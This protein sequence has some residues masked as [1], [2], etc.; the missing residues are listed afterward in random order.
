LLFILGA[1][2]FTGEL[3]IDFRYVWVNVVQSK[4]CFK[5]IVYTDY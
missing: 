2:S 1:S 5:L 4:I 3:C